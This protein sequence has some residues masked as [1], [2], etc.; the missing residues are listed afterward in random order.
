[1]ARH[2]QPSR[3]VGCRRSFGSLDV[4]DLSDNHITV[5]PEWFGA[6]NELW[7]LP[8]SLAGLS[9]LEELDASGNNL[10]EVQ[11]WALHLVEEEE[12]S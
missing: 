3:S 7:E 11:E 5:V 9:S 1:M 12:G 4:L 2:E 10:G 6:D 8:E